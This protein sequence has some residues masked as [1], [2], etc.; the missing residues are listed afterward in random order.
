VQRE[1][2][3][4]ERARPEGSRHAVE[5]EQEDHRARDMDHGARRVMAPRAQAEELGV[6]HVRDPR[7]RMPVRRR[8]RAEGPTQAVDRESRADV[9]V[10]GD[11]DRVVQADEARVQDR[12][13]RRGRRE[14]ESE[15]H[16]D[17]DLA[18]GA[19]GHGLGKVT[20]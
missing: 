9:V 8:A 12:G 20:I 18:T 4:D 3:R 11:V 7:Q 5:G 19:R 17:A 15:R 6:E 10:V 1:E 13:V 14:R 16:D 2:R